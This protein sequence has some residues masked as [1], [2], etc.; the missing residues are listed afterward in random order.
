MGKEYLKAKEKD[1]EE[2]IDFINYVFS[3]SGGAVDFPS[4]LPKLYKNKDKAKY[5][6]IIKVDNKIRGVVG[7]FPF[8]LSL[9]DEN[10]NVVGIGTVAVHPYSKG[11]GY[12]KELMNKAIEEMKSENVDISVL[13]GYRQRYEY[14]GYEPCGE[15]ITFNIQELNINYKHNELI[16]KSI[17]LKLL[18]EN[19][20]DILGRAYEL[21]SKKSVKVLRKKEE[22]LDVLKSWNCSIYSVFKEENFIGYISANNGLIDEIVLQDNE[23]LNIV[24]ASYIKTFNHNEV[25]FRVPTYEKEKISQLIKICENYF[26]SKNNNFRIFNY[27]KIVR[28]MLKLKSTYSKLEDGEYNISIIDYGILNIKVKGNKVWVN[29]IEGDFDIELN[30]LQAME[31]LFSPIKS[32][33]DFDKEIPSFLHSWFPLPLYIE[34][35]DCV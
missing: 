25:S 15:Q 30:E 12:M 20:E 27:E 28:L 5:H 1:Y 18:D 22:F 19:D 2:L 24:I 9:L 6:H 35:P 17:S 32:Y 11:Q 16:D 3:H 23:D 7:A 13:S 31:F 4:L 10:I 21:H 26:I 34:N 14:F 8:T 33:F 29:K